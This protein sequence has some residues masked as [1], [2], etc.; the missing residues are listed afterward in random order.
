VTTALPNTHHS[1]QHNST[2]EDG[3]HRTEIWRKKVG[4]QYGWKMPEAAVQDMAG[5]R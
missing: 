1:E 2:E 4:F 3:H 5:W